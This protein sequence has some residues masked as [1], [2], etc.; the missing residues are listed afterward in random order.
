MGGSAAHGISTAAPYPLVHIYM[1]QTIDYYLEKMLQ[2]KYQGQN[3]EVINAAVTGYQVFQHTA[4]LMSELLDYHPDLVIFM[5]GA[6]DHF[7]NNPDF[8]PM[9]DNPYQFWKPRL[10]HPSIIGWMEYGLLWLTKFSGFARG[11]YAWELN[12]DAASNIKKPLQPYKT[13]SSDKESIDMY[14]MTA[15][16]NILRFIEININMLKNAKINSIISLQPM[17]VLRDTTLLSTNEK[18]FLHIDRNAQLV[19][20]FVV[21]D[22]TNLT[23]RYEVPFLDLNIDFNNIKSGQKQLFVDYC[24][25]SSEG[26]KVVAG[27]LFP[28]V[29]SI[30]AQRNK[31]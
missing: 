25:L 10:Q 22:L 24:H 8:D 30:F 9:R 16:K 2:Q 12:K 31:N 4:Y 13:F 28:V 11:L 3:F 1:D 27:S 20:P 29:D 21:Q 19:Y 14:K 18:T 17:L 15:T 23:F 6:N 5:D 26:G 7:S